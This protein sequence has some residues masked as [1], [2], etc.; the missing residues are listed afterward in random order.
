MENQG[1]FFLPG[2][3]STV[4][5]KVD[6]LFLFIGVASLIVF[7]IV[8]FGLV[9]FGFKYRARSKE[10]TLSEHITHNTAL[11]LLWTIIPTIL[12][13]I[14]FIWGFK[15]FL[16]LN[17]VPRNAME[18]KVTGKKW[19]WSFDYPNGYT[20]INELTVPE[21]TPV[22]LLMSSEDVIHSFYV[23]NFRMK[24]D[25]VPNRY[26]VTWFEAVDPGEYNLFCTEY[27]GTG[28]SEMIGKVTVLSKQDYAAWEVSSGEDNTAGLTLEDIGQKVYREKACFTCHTLDGS[29]L[30]GPSFKGAFGRNEKLTDGTEIVVDENYLRRSLLEPAAQIVEGFAPV[31]P[32]YQGL[33]NDRE[34]DGIIAYIKTLK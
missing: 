3:G 29:R 4:A 24:M 20:V 10:V 6:A 22:K 25:V 1:N 34:L 21:D 5:P 32:T 17:V 8:V 11:E 19:F 27:C 12:V 7:A 23:P 2:Q 14:V 9:Y 30:V 26:S 13:V 18:I 16:T 33:L 31:M 15:T 28:H